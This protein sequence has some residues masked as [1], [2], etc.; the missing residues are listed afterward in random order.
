MKTPA[1]SPVRGRRASVRPLGLCR[2][3]AEE[4]ADGGG[5]RAN[6]RRLLCQLPHLMELHM[7]FRHHP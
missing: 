5:V 6:R 2:G 3:C 1:L 4:I 7:A